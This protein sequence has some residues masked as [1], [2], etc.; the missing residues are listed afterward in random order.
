MRVLVFAHVPPPHHGQSYMIQQMLENL[1]KPGSGE[2][3]VLYHVNARLSDG[4]DDIGAWRIGKFFRL[5]NY[6]LQAWWLRWKYA[7]EALYYVPAPA[8]RSALYRDWL[9]LALVGPCFRVWIFHW[10]STGLG[11]WVREAAFGGVIHRLEAWITRRLFDRHDLSCVL[12]EWGRRDVEVFSP[13]RV[14]V[15]A[16]GIPDPCPDFASTLLPERQLRWRQRSVHQKE[17]PAL[18]Q[19]LYLAH[20]TRSKGLFDAVEAVALANAR[21]KQRGNV[22]RISLT[23]AGAFIS[24][25]EEAAFRERIGHDDFLLDGSSGRCA[26]TYAGFVGPE[27]KDRLL[28]QADALCFAS[29]F[30]NE[31]QPVS[32]IEAL[33]YGL[34]VV[35]SRW[36]ALPEMISPVLAYLVDSSDPSA[37][38]EVLPTLANEERF[39]QYREHFL[40]HYS[41]ATHCARLRE[42]FLSVA[43]A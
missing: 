11:Q 13:L 41:L 23:V 36:R 39:T 12:N 34:P 8:K 6:I 40:N 9:V 29:F 15:V 18:L 17:A 27:E 28:R 24:R 19:V 37:L 31:G 21:L 3:L 16:N 5:A 43:Q 33:A 22:L 26:V 35:L 42:A 20:A 38:A 1:G 32:V 4:M 30:P 14:A 10:H 25:D 2:D 7:P